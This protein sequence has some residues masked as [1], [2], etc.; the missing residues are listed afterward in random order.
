M[1]LMEW[2]R[3][4]SDV[5]CT[6]R[7]RLGGCLLAHYGVG[8]CW[9]RRVASP[10]I[11]MNSMLTFSFQM[12]SCWSQNDPSKVDFSFPSHP[13][14][15]PYPIPTHTSASNI[16]CHDGLVSAIII[17]PSL[18][19]LDPLIPLSLVP[20]LAPF[21]F[22]YTINPIVTILSSPPHSIFFPVLP[23]S[24]HPILSTKICFC[25]ISVSSHHH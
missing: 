14:Y 10:V 24:H 11:R 7:D 6:A 23:S 17:H 8:V 2:F 13:V 22:S 9:K 16:Q 5:G 25:S 4:S 20:R 1:R 21:P 15:R 18:R 3:W 12:L 19:C